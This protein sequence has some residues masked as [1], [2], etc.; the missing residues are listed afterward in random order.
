MCLA[1]NCNSLV[2]ASATSLDPILS[3]TPSSLLVNDE[4]KVVTSNVTQLACSR[5]TRLSL[6]ATAQHLRG[7]LAPQY[8][9]AMTIAT[10]MALADTR[11]MSIFIMEGADVANKQVAQTP[12][13]IHLPNGNKVMSTHICDINIPGLPTVL[14]GHIV[15]SLGI[16]SL[17]GICP[18]C[19]A[20]CTVVFN[21]DKCDVMFNGKVILRGYKGP[22]TNLWMLPITNK[23]CTT[24]GPTILP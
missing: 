23:V 9:N 17:M 14:M 22:T 20:G 7:N 5:Q 6:A 18:I 13:T 15:P 1:N 16:T 4:F 24:P 8:L 10:H 3:S 21:N 2:S 11:T 19:K 12:L